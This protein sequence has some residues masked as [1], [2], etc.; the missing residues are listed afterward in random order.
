M[1]DSHVDVVGFWTH[2]H[3]NIRST[4]VL[5]E[6]L[7]RFCPSLPSS[8]MNSVNEAVH[9]FVVPSA[10]FSTSFV[11]ED[12]PGVVPEVMSTLTRLEVG[13]RLIET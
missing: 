6:I 10:C 7:S 1:S 2:N 3:K 9:Y 8:P 5:P 11:T 4:S 12:M 13:D